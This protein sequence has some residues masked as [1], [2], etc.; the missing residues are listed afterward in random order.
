MIHANDADDDNDG[1]WE[2]EKEEEG[3][4]GMREKISP[5]QPALCQLYQR[6]PSLNWWQFHVMFVVLPN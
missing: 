4:S 5:N 1:D 6:Q 3:R 2:E